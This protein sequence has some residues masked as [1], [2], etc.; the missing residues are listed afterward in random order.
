MLRR[1]DQWVY[2]A[3]IAQIVEGGSSL[4][5]LLESLNLDD[6][7]HPEDFP[8]HLGTSVEVPGVETRRKDP[9]LLV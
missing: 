3:S 2:K 4:G 8:L 5:L 9:L 6:D 7:I 1:E